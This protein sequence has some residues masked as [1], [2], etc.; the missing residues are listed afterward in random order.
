MRKQIPSI[1]QIDKLVRYAIADGDKADT[2]FET[3]FNN[4]QKVT[5]DEIIDDRLRRDIA[6]DR[7]IARNGTYEYIIR[8]NDVK[9]EID[10]RDGIVLVRDTV[11]MNGDRGLYSAHIIE[12]INA[13][14]YW[15]HKYYMNIRRI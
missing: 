7:C 14:V 1:D 4:L 15:L 3:L 8:F 10:I 2:A 9:V 5:L 13:W 12:N 6:K 11:N